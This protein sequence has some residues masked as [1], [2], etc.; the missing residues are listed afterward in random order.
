MSE[1]ISYSE[2]S[3]I[4]KKRFINNIGKSFSGGIEVVSCL[5]SIIFIFAGVFMCIDPTGKIAQ[6]L[7]MEFP[8]LAVAIFFTVVGML[9][10]YSTVLA[11]QRRTRDKK[12]TIARQS[13]LSIQDTKSNSVVNKC[14]TDSI[15]KGLLFLGITIGALASIVNLIKK[16]KSDYRYKS[17]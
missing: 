9:L 15:I 6:L 10:F 14:E 5:S 4:A 12:D 8:R 7:I 11:I 1:K 17:D 16:Y 13:Q 3:Y 2:P